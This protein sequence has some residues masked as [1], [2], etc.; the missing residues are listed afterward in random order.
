MKPAPFTL[1]SPATL[2]EAL[3]VLS[4]VAEADGKVLAGGQSLVPAMALRLARPGHLVDINGIAGLD[5]L[6]ITAGRIVI[7]A[8][9]RHAAFQTPVEPGPTGRLLAAVVRH[10]A[11]HPI[12]ARG[13]FCGSL[14]HADPASEWCLAAIALGATIVA[15]SIRGVREIAA[16]DFLQ[17]T[18]TTAL[19]P[20]EILTEVRIPLLADGSLWSFQEVSRRKGDFAA[21]MVI[22]SYRLVDGRINAPCVAVGGVEGRPRRIAEAER[23]LD[24]HPPDSR[25]FARAGEAA[26]ASVEAMEDPANSAQYR[27][28][29]VRTLTARTLEAAAP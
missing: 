29:L 24:G 28:H 5:T 21:A 13:T 15:R 9:V 16:D 7:G 25:L 10:I 12:R 17:G 2:D 14:A 8:R 23:L 27:R 22:A 4:R 19:A 18:M 3:A 26:C 1:H 11:H 20:D 6:T